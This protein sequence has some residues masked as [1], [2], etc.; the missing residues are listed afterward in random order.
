MTA[1]SLEPMPKST[2]RLLAIHP[3]WALV[4]LLVG[5]FEEFFL[6]GYAQFT[7]ARGI[8]FWR[9]AVVLSCIFGGSHLKNQGETGAGALAGA[10]D[11]ALFLSH[12]PSYPHL[13]F[14]DGFHASWDWG[15]SSFTQFPIAERS[16][17]NIY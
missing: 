8:G 13:W 17:A 5:L 9:A 4:F 16:R 12:S 2:S 7:L 6:R 11:G 3:A 1:G 10:H 15:E 14:A